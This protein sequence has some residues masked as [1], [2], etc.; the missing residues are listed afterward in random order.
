MN[1]KKDP[2]ITR[3]EEEDDEDA[4]LGLGFSPPAK[5]SQANPKSLPL[6]LVE[7]C[8]HGEKKTQQQ[9]RR[10]CESRERSGPRAVFVVL[11]SAEFRA[12]GGAGERGPQVVR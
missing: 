3:K 2:A 1:T 9:N 7:I 10:K 5:P 11:T 8:D 12:R 6:R 4:G